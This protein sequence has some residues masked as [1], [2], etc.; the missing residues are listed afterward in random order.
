MTDDQKAAGLQWNEQP[1]PLN[2]PRD[3]LDEDPPPPKL[4]PKVTLAQQVDAITDELVS[5]ASWE[6]VWLMD[7]RRPSEAFLARKRIYESIEQTLKLLERFEGPFVEL[8][9]QAGRDAAARAR[10]AAG[11]STRSR[12]AP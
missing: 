7:G 10:A 6:R 9:K 1:A 2:D 11:S 8:V 12:R 3:V 5:I 4:V